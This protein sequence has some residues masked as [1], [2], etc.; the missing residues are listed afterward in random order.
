MQFHID[1]FQC[2]ES[3]FVGSFFCGVVWCAVPRNVERQS[4]A[5]P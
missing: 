2:C 5:N 4:D 3:G 1:V